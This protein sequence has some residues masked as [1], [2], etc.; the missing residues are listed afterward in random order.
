MKIPLVNLFTPHPKP[1]PEKVIHEFKNHFP[2]AFNIEWEFKKGNYEA[3]F[4]LEEAEHIA[5]ISEEG[6]LKEHKRNLW[7]NELPVRITKECQNLGEI[8]NAIAIFKEGRQFFEVIIRDSAFKRK[9]LLF[10]QTAF[11]IQSR[12]L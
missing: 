8:M 11:L 7:P 2:N 12:K 4:Y 10:D 6:K 5:L 9:V 3:V 1:V